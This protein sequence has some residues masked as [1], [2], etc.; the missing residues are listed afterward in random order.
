MKYRNQNCTF[1]RGIDFHQD[2]ID[3]PTRNPD[4]ITFYLYLTDVS[5]TDAP[6]Q[7]LKRSNKILNQVFPHKLIKNLKKKF[8]HFYK[9]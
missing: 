7:V 6:I 2:I 8:L 3:F 4:F 1:F 9:K 5:E